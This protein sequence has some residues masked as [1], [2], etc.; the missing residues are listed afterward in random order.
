MTEANILNFIKFGREG[1]QID[2]TAAK[3]GNS[4]S[5]LYDSLVN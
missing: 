3:G 2:P 5:A 4:A 1:L